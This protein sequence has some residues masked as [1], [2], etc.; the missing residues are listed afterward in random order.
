MNKYSNTSTHFSFTYLSLTTLVGLLCISHLV[1]AV[2]LSQRY[3]KNGNRPQD[4]IHSTQIDSLKHGQDCDLGLMKSDQGQSTKDSLSHSLIS[5]SS[6]SGFDNNMLDKITTSSDEPRPASSIIDIL[7][8][9]AQFSIVLD[10][11]QRLG[12]V[13]LINGARNVT[14]F[15]PSNDAFLGVNPELVTKDLLLYHLLNTTF[16]T[17]DLSG[18]KERGLS[19]AIHPSYL[20]AKHFKK[21]H[22]SVDSQISLENSIATEE[23]DSSQNAENMLVFINKYPTSDKRYSYSVGNNPLSTVHITKSDLM[24]SRNR[25]VVH[26]VNKLMKI[27]ESICSMLEKNPNTQFFYKLF[28]LEYNCSLPVFSVP[29]TLFVPLDLAFAS[30]LNQIETDY[31]FSQWGH[32]DR[33]KILDRHTITSQL[34]SSPLIPDIAKQSHQSRNTS[35][36]LQTDDGSIWNISLSMAVN[37]TFSSKTSNNI[38]NDGIIHYYDSFVAGSDGNINSLITFTPEKYILGL[39]CESFVKQVKFRGLKGLINESSSD[40]KQ[41]I[42][43]PIEDPDSIMANDASVSLKSDIIETPNLGPVPDVVSADMNIESIPTTLYHFVDGQYHLDV[44]EII[45]SNYLLKSKAMFKRLGYEHQ[46]IKVTAEEDSRD[47]Y[48]NLHDKIVSGPYDIGNTTIYLIDSSL[49]A[50]PTI[51]LAVSSILQA[52]RSAA[53]L[54]QLDLLD[55]P[56]DNGWT[57][58]LPTTVAWKRLGL[59]TIYL[60]N[61]TTALRQVLESYILRTLFYS[62]SKTI[63]TSL[64]N[65]RN[66]TVSTHPTNKNSKDVVHTNDGNSADVSGHYTSEDDYYP[67]SVYVNNFEYRVEYANVLSSSGVIHAVNSINIPDS[68]VINVENILSSIEATLFVD[69]LIARNLS[70]VLDPQFA[71]TILAPSNRVLL[72]NNITVDTPDIDVLLRLHI[73]PSNPVHE[74]FE[75][76]ETLSMQEN[77]HLSAHE[78]DSDVFVVTVVE[79]DS[80]HEVRVLQRGDTTKYS[81]SNQ[82]ST[83]LYV[84]NFF[85]PDWIIK[86][87]PP[88]IPPFH[89]RTSFAILL[90]VVF[91][92]IIIFFLISIALLFFLSSRK[93]RQHS[94][95]G[96][97]NGSEISPDRRP[98]LPR[99]SSSASS[100]SAG[101]PRRHRS[102]RSG[103][104]SLNGSPPEGSANQ[105]SA[106]YGATSD[107][108][109]TVSPTEYHGTYYSNSSAAAST[110]S[111]H[112]SR[113]GSAKSI[114]SMTSEHSVSDPIPT[115]KVQSNR[116]HGKH[117]NL[118]R[119]C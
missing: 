47:I 5:E 50:P 34:V 116:E 16:M 54:D 27:P 89:L 104:H 68:V 38:A 97:A 21:I 15:A 64:Y 12:L 77:I 59:V 81:S 23:L 53:Y 52:S 69:L 13:P 2:P 80:H 39:G 85:S 42:F 91:G 32:S 93:T 40:L 86:P 113:R 19:S 98:L 25:G 65:G 106:N 105:E 4:Q 94:F 63:Q 72:A 24:A 76:V 74:L 84:D 111:Q 101:G 36:L 108:S 17:S 51:D 82:V 9:S 44:N 102:H 112:N 96:M 90:G 62:N 100:H 1:T 48:L 45:N 31:L 11:I 88:F 49:D 110:R 8:A 41:T 28:D 46:H 61:N 26:V 119:I 79:S 43:S 58:L 114:S 109:T 115:P 57:V 103:T 37:G 10:H 35:A 14:F 71:Y 55:L 60:E 83:V 67:F 107:Q 118:P 73:L 30:Q 22:N 29:T 75:G 18:S 3:I 7:S 20:S 117:L 56:S 92:A 6:F 33:K 95:S 99:K 70:Y 87:S 78:V 66:V